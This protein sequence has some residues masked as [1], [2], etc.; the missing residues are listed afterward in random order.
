[1]C[2][3]P[4]HNPTRETKT[5]H[6]CKFFN[7]QFPQ[8]QRTFWLGLILLN[9]TKFGFGSCNNSI[10]DHLNGFFKCETG[11]RVVLSCDDI[12]TQACDSGLYDYL[13]VA[14][15]WSYENYSL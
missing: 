15:N 10:F 13:L 1:M 3:E 8:H 2:F 12:A 11:A 5:D 9:C 6:Y 4:N 7:F 14:P